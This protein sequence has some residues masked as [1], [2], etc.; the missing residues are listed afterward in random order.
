M[1][2]SRLVALFSIFYLQQAYCHSCSGNKPHKLQ[3]NIKFDKWAQ[4]V[5]W[6]IL[7]SSNNLMLY[8]NG[9]NA[10]DYAEVEDSVCLKY[11]C[12]T[13][14]INDT[15]GDGMYSYGYFGW[16][17]LKLDDAYVTLGEQTFDGA[18]TYLYFCT[19]L[20]DSTAGSQIELEFETFDYNSDIYIVGSD[21]SDYE[22]YY[23][24]QYEFPDYFNSSVLNTLYLTNARALTSYCYKI[25]IDTSY[26]D[27]SEGYYSIDVKLDEN[28]LYH[29]DQNTLT[30]LNFDLCLN[31]SFTSAPTPEP[32]FDP[33]DEQLYVS[34]DGRFRASA[35]LGCPIS[36]YSSGSTCTDTKTWEIDG[37]CANPRLTVSVFQSDYD[38]PTEQAFVLINNEY[39]GYCEPLNNECTYD[40]Q[41]C[42][43]TD[44][45]DVTDYLISDNKLNNDVYFS[46]FL[47][48][49]VLSLLWWLRLFLMDVI[50]FS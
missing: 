18:Q 4:E 13:L 2:M 50:C 11:G 16:Y 48:S 27:T 5:S 40:W 36:S 28:T 29:H 33:A 20:F 38:W 19:Q 45:M 10:D 47:F 46:V 23:L 26:V 49:F 21:D 7:D 8:G 39:F 37:D 1:L 25:M 22:T 42:N 15:Y 30:D 6:G 24:N 12:Y 14:E 31:Q 3:F 35:Y 41:T 17:T 34:N 44:S 32:T 9:T 43:F